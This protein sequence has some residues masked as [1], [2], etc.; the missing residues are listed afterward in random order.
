MEPC[1][2]CGCKLPISELQEHVQLHFL[3]DEAADLGRA[4][5][6]PP[7]SC[8]GIV[9]DSDDET[10]T[11][12]KVC[13]PLGCGAMVLLEELDS[14][15]EAHR[16]SQHCQQS[17]IATSAAGVPHRSACSWAVPCDNL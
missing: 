16:Y 3:E 11:A 4:A 13:C 2:V 9:I 8:G 12:G 10:E 15:E 17:N 1:P 7:S 14:H 5:A 6:A